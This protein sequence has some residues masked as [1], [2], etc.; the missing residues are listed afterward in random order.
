MLYFQAADHC[1]PKWS[2]MALVTGTCN[3]ALQ[4]YYHTL[5]WIAPNSLRPNYYTKFKSNHTPT[6][7]LFSTYIYSLDIS[8]NQLTNISQL[9]RSQMPTLQSLNL[10]WNNIEFLQ[11]NYFKDIS[12]LF[13]IDL[14]HN[15]L[16][17]VPSILSCRVPDPR[18]DQPSIGYLPL[19]RLLNLSNNQLI[20][21]PAY[22]S[23]HVTISNFS[24]NQS[25][26]V[27]GRRFYDLVN[28]IHLD[29]S[30]NRLRT[31]C[32]G[33]IHSNSKLVDHQAS[34]DCSLCIFGGIYNLHLLNVSHNNITNISH[35][36]FFGLTQL[37]TLDFSKNY[38]KILTHN[39][40]RDLH[41]LEYLILRQNHI[42][43][44]ES[45]TF[46]HL[47]QVKHVSLED[48]NLS[49]LEEDLFDE[50]SNLKELQLKNN[51]LATVP[52]AVSKS[53]LS[54]KCLFILQEALWY[55]AFFATFWLVMQCLSSCV[56]VY[57]I[58]IAL[59][60]LFKFSY[61]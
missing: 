10:S 49:D 30:C 22:L 8:H 47:H 37:N 45:N 4:L 27:E 15:Q 3:P 12:R 61:C 38:I 13:Q 2:F 44:I 56:S 46:H 42:E 33:D 54:S 14:S 7:M 34:T 57:L 36:W 1:I 32:L 19:L 26:E 55:S 51:D 59:P 28:L 53:E 31:F 50:I 17:Q 41:S 39:V 24:S 29:L 35:K 43:V 9:M 20:Y 40:F 6:K 58:V 21:L 16:E 18:T 60:G 11:Q 52:L 5:S 23:S 25:T 48:N